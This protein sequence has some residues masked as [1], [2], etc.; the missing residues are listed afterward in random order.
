MCGHKGTAVQV[1]EYPLD[2]S[3][4]NQEVRTERS[5]NISV[6]LLHY[7]GK[8]IEDVV[9]SGMFGSISLSTLTCFPLRARN[10]GSNWVG[11]I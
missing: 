6:S 4:Q 10:G 5:V 2:P 11:G 9:L 1:C 7:R 3:E 8:R